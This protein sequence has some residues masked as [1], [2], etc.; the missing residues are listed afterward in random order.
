M[1]V[2]TRGRE[3][4]LKRSVN[5]GIYISI[6]FCRSKCSYCNFA[7]GVFSQDRMALFTERV[8]RDIYSAVS[9]ADS[10]HA[11]LDLNVDTIYLG[12]GTPS[13]L[14]PEMFQQIIATLHSEF[15][16]TS[17][18]EFT[19]ECAPGTISDAMLDAFLQNGVN[20]ISLGVQSFVDQ[21]ARAVARMHDRETT[22]QDVGRLR[23]RGIANINLDLIAG[24]PHQTMESWRY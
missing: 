24:L 16:V 19:V 4:L 20:R 23:S 6:P 13:I 18:L 3:Q 21:E 14:P 1:A 22:I 8:C 17:D 2:F 10:L 7:S 12:G 15:N 9:L 5:L 11:T